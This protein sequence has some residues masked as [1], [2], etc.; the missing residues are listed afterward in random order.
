[1]KIVTSIILALCAST[2]G[3]TTHTEIVLARKA[4]LE[5]KLRNNHRVVGIGIGMEGGLYVYALCP[6]KGIPRKFQGVPVYVQCTDS[7]KAQ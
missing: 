7:P 3:L 6:V 5:H 2:V 4:A 1:M